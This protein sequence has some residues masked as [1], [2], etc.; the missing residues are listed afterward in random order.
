MAIEISI[1]RLGWN[2]DEGVF[3]G[4]LK[5]DGETVRPGDPLFSL[6]GEKATQDIESFDEGILRISPASPGVGDRIAV[7]AVIGYLLRP[8]EPD[9]LDPHTHAPQGH[10]PDPVTITDTVPGHPAT[11]SPTTALAPDRHDR[12]RPKISPLARRIARELGVDWTGLRGSGKTGRIRKV[13][14]LAAATTVPQRAKPTIAAVAD[15][16]SPG[17]SVP[18]GSIRRTIAGRMVESH[19]ISAPVT[20]STTVDASNLVNL[21]QQFKATAPLGREVPGYTDFLV[22]LTAL[23][24]RDHPLLHARWVDDRLDIPDEA[25][26]GIAVDTDA[27]LFVPVIR[28]AASLGLGQIAAQ[29]RDLARRAREQKLAPGDMQGGTFTITNLGAFGIETFTP[30]I[31]LPE[32]AILGVGRIERQPVFVGEQVVPRERLSLS[33]T[34]DHRIIDGAPAARFLQALGQLIENPGPW[35]IA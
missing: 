14:I 4:W 29:S 24:L 3:A 25:H 2:M 5:A 22:K 16:T 23:V 10:D 35:L 32:C 34:F 26:I 30:I 20:L 9:P 18:I 6:E 13:D 19:R 21:R 12:D 27:G 7:G 28:G 31:N 15:T 11:D 33:L 17:R 8:G 1:P